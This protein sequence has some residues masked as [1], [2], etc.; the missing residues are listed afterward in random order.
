VGLGIF[1]FQ[2]IDFLMDGTAVYLLEEGHIMEHPMPPKTDYMH[3]TW[4]LNQRVVTEFL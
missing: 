3:N 4:G 1:W 2:T